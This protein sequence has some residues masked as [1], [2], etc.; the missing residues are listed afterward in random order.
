LA[1]VRVEFQLLVT[2]VG[3]AKFNVTVQ[4]LGVVVPLLV[5][6]TSTWYEAA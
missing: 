4:L 5:T 2:F 3:S 1:P 6:D